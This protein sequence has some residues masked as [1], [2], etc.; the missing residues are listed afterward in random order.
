MEKEFL[1]ESI[2]LEDIDIKCI[3][4]LRAKSN[5]GKEYSGVYCI[6]EVLELTNYGIKIV[7]ILPGLEK[8]V[9]VII[10]KRIVIG[11]Y[12]LISLAS[13]MLI[14]VFTRIK[15]RKIKNN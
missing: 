9:K 5:R 13:I 7:E 1:E 4:K 15:E 14:I 2:E 11:W 8:P 6:N 3:Y 12:W 10:Y